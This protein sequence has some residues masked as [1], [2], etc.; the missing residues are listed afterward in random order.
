LITASP[1]ENWRRPPGCPLDNSVPLGEL[2]E[3]TRMPSYHVDEDY[4]ARC[5]NQQPLPE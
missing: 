5:E 4:L 3:T 1:L 2:E